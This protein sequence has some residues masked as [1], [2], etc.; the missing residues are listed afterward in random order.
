M[1][2]HNPEMG[3]EEHMTG[4]NGLIAASESKKVARGFAIEH[5]DGCQ[6][7]VS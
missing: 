3:L 1:T 6:V 2:A 5:K 7:S 4:G